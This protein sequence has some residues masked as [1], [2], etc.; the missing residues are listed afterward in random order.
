MPSSVGREPLTPTS[1]ALGAWLEMEL[2]GPERFEDAGVADGRMVVRSPKAG[3]E[4]DVI[5]EHGIE[6][7]Q[8]RA[9]TCQSASRSILVCK[10]I[11]LPMKVDQHFHQY[12]NPSLTPQ[13]LKGHP[14]APWGA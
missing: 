2:A 12:V 7:S 4:K 9:L 11:K 8:R 3:A 13:E 14:C 6:V 10:D 1:D 5:L